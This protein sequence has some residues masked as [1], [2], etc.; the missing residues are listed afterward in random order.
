MSARTG[1]FLVVCLSLMALMVI[2][3]FAVLHVLRQEVDTAT[4]NQRYLLAQGAARQGLDHAAERILTDYG[5][6]TM[7]V[8]HATGSKKGNVYGAA[9]VPAITIL[10]GQWRAPFTAETISPNFEA[11]WA[12]NNAVN[13][14][15]DAR[16]EDFVLNPLAWWGG[17]VG[18]WWGNTMY[19]GRGRYYE[20]GYYNL[21]TSAPGTTCW[22]NVAIGILSLG[23]KLPERNQA[24]FYDEQFRRVVPTGDPTKDRTKARFRLRYVVGVEDLSG[25]L[26]I[27]PIPNVQMIAGTATPVDY[28]TPNATYPWM[29]TAINQVANISNPGLG[30]LYSAQFENVIQGRGYSTNCDFDHSSSGLAGDPK[31]FPLMYR[32]HPERNPFTGLWD[33]T[34]CWNSWID[35]YDTTQSWWPSALVTNQ[36]FFYDTQPNKSAITNPNP[37]P[38]GLAEGGEALPD[39]C[40]AGIWNNLNT[41]MNSGI[42]PDSGYPNAGVFMHCL[43]GPQLSFENV[44]YAAHG[45]STHFDWPEGWDKYALT[46]FGHRETTTGFVP[47]SGSNKW[48]QGPVDTPFLVNFMTAPTNIINHMLNAYVAPQSKGCSYGSVTW[49][50][51]TGYGVTTGWPTTQTM[52]T[53]AIDPNNPANQSGG[54]G[55]DLFVNTTVPWQ[56]GAPVCFVPWNPPDRKD[57]NLPGAQ[58]PPGAPGQVISPDYYAADL[59]EPLTKYPGPLM[60]GSDTV[61]ATAG[62][63]AQGGDDLGQHMDEVAVLGFENSGSLG[64]PNA[65]IN[66]YCFGYDC[67]TGGYYYSYGAGFPSRT[68]GSFGTYVPNPAPNGQTPNDPLADAVAWTTAMG[69]TPPA[70]WGTTDPFPGSDYVVKNPVPTQLLHQYSYFYD[71]TAALAQT[72]AVVRDEYKQY[73]TTNYQAPENLFGTP[74]DP[75]PAK[76]QSLYDIDGLFL[77]EMGES[78]K[79]PGSGPP[80]SIGLVAYKPYFYMSTNTGINPAFTYVSSKRE[81]WQAYHPANNIYSLYTANNGAGIA[82]TTASALKRAHVMELLLNDFRMSFFGSSPGYGGPGGGGPQ[83]MPLDFLGND[84]N[85]YCSCYAGKDADGLPCAPKGTTPPNYF[86][87]AG[88]FFLG[89]SHYY[90]I[91]SRGEVWDNVLDRKTSEATLDS[92]FCVDPDG[93]DPTQSQF[94]YQRWLANHYPAMLPTVKR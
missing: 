2:L 86:T 34:G 53:D 71:M 35:G 75:N 29:Q 43:M 8:L 94:L 19:D 47:G 83:F 44:A 78:M 10:D 37:A 58:N 36:L 31:T 14:D 15:N 91:F 81:P 65:P 85:L 12:D 49:V 56:G 45:E 72:I 51:V 42:Y 18:G 89:K 50:E 77:A 79:Q 90:R 16:Y 33:G 9:T 20:P 69:I 41:G 54:N 13:E 93:T 27:N 17:E 60:E 3:C 68:E 21:T 52:R 6:T 80:G 62:S 82:T 84:P 70:G 48:Y 1:T 87:I 7:S 32:N 66:S 11:T 88:D 25:H 24:V 67:F 74:G 59:R 38:V 46:P 92:V 64:T 61:S 63:V 76:Y 4:G 28:R 22:P 30:M 40:G 57:A 39:G 26:L 73:W 55:R 23:A 5:Q